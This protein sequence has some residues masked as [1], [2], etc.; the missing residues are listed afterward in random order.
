M[1]SFLR[2]KKIAKDVASG[3]VFIWRGGSEG[4]VSWLIS[5]ISIFIVLAGL[6]SFVS[7][8]HRSH[9]QVLN[10]SSQVTMLPM[11]HPLYKKSERIAPF[12]LRPYVLDQDLSFFRVR[13]Q[14]FKDLSSVEQ[15]AAIWRELPQVE[16]KQILPSVYQRG[17]LFL[18]ENNTE[19]TKLLPTPV[20]QLRAYILGDESLAPR[21]VDSVF[22]YS[23]DLNPEWYGVKLRWIVGVDSKGRLEHCM[24]LDRMAGEDSRQIE[25]W[26]RQLKFNPGKRQ[27]GQI[28]VRLEAE[29]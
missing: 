13:K 21:L 28:T 1:F 25:Q 8:D 24:L 11:Q 5:A 4:S 19:S 17:T 12:A 18:A 27:I 6:F 3:L 9:A 16:M 26:L 22:H 10:H 7:I 20:K 14:F 2:Q 15:P 23:Q 29:L